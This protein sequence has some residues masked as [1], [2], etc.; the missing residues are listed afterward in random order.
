MTS[1]QSPARHDGTSDQVVFYLNGGRVS[2]HGADVFLTLADFLRTR[3]GATGTKIV[4]EEGDCGACSVLYGRLSD[5]GRVRYEPINSC[6]QFV[7]QAAGVHVVT[8]EG[9]RREGVLHPVQQAMIDSHGAQC[10]YCTPGFVVTMCAMYERDGVT[11]EKTVRDALTGNLCRCTGYEPIIKAALAVAPE[12]VKKLEDVYPLD[13]SSVRGTSGDSLLVRHGD[14]TFFAPRTVEE[15]VAFKVQNPGTVIVQGATDIAVTRNK[16]G[17]EP[18]TVMTLTRIRDLDAVEIDERLLTVG[19]NVTLTRLESLFRERQPEFFR[20][21]ELFGAPQIRNAGTLAGNI[22][23][24]SPIADTV[25]F[26]YVM[27]AQ[28]ELTGPGGARRI[29]VDSFYRGYKQ[30]DLAPDEII[31]RVFVPLPEAEATGDLLRLF[32]VSKRRNLDIATVTAA[33]RLQM[34]GGLIRNAKIAF[35]GVG[36]IVMRLRE[37]ESFLAGKAADYE[38]LR[39]AGSV[40]RAEITPISDVRGSAEFRQQ[41]TENIFLKFHHDISRSS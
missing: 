27:E 39:A 20:I 41:L 34:A 18:K 5:E 19:A 16:R 3:V 8:V 6:I 31:T 11:D 38:S 10:G 2:A 1:D 37:T 28:L 33:I 21:L 13:R 32:K 23:N 15:A 26:L 7:H 40:A 24:A 17:I 12:S 4:C 36:P 14:R 22:A 35:G 25:P 29:A 30:L 9:L